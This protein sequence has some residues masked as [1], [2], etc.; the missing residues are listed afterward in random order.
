MA[1]SKILCMKEGT[2]SYPGKHLKIAI[3]YITKPE[4]TD[5][6]L[7]VGGLNCQSDFAYDQMKETKLRYDKYSKRQGYH[8]IISFNEGEVDEKTAFNA[9]TDFAT[10]YIGKEYEAIYAVHNNTAH[11]HGHIIWNSVSRT[12]G[13]KYRYEKGDWERV[14]QPLVNKICEKYNLKTLNIE[15]NVGLKDEWNDRKDGKFVWNSMI[16]RDFDACIIQATDF[17]MFLDM[18]ERKGY[19]VKFNKYLAVK[20]KGMQ[21]YRRSKTLGAEYTLDRIYER[22]LSENIKDYKPERIKRPKL[23]YCKVPKGFNSKSKRKFSSMQKLYYGRLFRLYKIKNRPY[24]VYYQYKDDIK[25]M[26]ELQEQCLFLARNNIRSIEHLKLKKDKLESNL[27]EIQ[28]A[29]KQLN[30][31][32]KNFYQVFK[33]FK[34]MSKLEDAHFFFCSGDEAFADEES[35][36][37]KLEEELKDCGY[38]FNE[39]KNLYEHFDNELKMLKTKEK[40]IRKTI[41]IATSITADIKETKTINQKIDK[42]LRRTR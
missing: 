10:K 18:L 28:S 36:R 30:K 16:K 25:K 42:D 1:I 29:R 34:E 19:E 6:G 21:R 15:E 3:E 41:N 38:S 33:I 4:K 35:M 24:S 31:E 26:K 2:G 23:I 11:I 20:P 27:E 5:N 9:I 40:Q 22:I 14:I 39:A 13:R 37:R 12:T 7:L 17:D 8:L 32:R